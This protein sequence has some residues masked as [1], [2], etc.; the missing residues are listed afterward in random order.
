M[1][2]EEGLFGFIFVLGGI[3]CAIAAS[4]ASFSKREPQ[5]YWT[6]IAVALSF[7]PFAIY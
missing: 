5:K 3:T 2:E 4:V 1:A 7:L 6:L